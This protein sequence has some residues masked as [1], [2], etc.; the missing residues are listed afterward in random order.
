M[1]IDG[2][3][4]RIRGLGG[5][6]AIKLITEFIEANPDLPSLD[7]AYTMRGMKYWGM[8]KRKEAINDYLTAIK[9]NP[10]SKARHALKATN[11]IM[12]YYNTDLYNP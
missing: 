8:Q 2:L 3:K 11:D 1:K 6:E 4:E 5:E 10:D 9:I 12:D 7:E